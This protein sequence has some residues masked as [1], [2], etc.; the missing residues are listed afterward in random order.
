M[1]E[2]KHDNMQY[3]GCGEW[4]CPDCDEWLDNEGW[5]QWQLAKKDKCI[6]NLK[7]KLANS[8]YSKVYAE[9]YDQGAL[10]TNKRL[11]E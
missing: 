6:A 8:S 11:E 3:M 4:S 7:A 10:D 1:S 2:C 5:Y 9:G